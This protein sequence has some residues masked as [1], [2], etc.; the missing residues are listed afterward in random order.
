MQGHTNEG[1]EEKDTG[2]PLTLSPTFVIGETGGN[3]RGGS[4]N[5]R[6]R[7]SPL[8]P[9]PSPRVP[10]PS[11]LTPRHSPLVTRH[12]FACALKD[13]F[14]VGVSA[15]PFRPDSGIRKTDPL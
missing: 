13:P 1:T 14:C 4:G 9:R 3:D 2:F 15:F 12:F 7:P 11:S 5:D 6:A 10:H 8:V